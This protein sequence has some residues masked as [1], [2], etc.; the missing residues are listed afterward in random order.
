MQFSTST[1][2]D[3]PAETVW[4]ILT[5]LAT[6]PSW[7][8]TVTATDGS[9]ALGQKVTVSVSA[10]PGRSFPVKVTALD[11]PTRMVWTGGMPLGLFTGTRTY[12]LARDDGTTQFAMEEVY[13]GPLASM[14]TRS[15][16]D[17]QPSFEEFATCL[18]AQAESIAQAA[19]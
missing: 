12:T 17:L 15:I 10:N 2:I 6:W 13:A 9:V 16:P 14:V 4:A 7:N 8:S 19:S 11:A 5:D 3:A 1:T 18:K